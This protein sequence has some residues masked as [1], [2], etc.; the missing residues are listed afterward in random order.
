[1]ILDFYLQRQIL[2]QWCWAAVAASIS[3]SYDPNSTWQQS[4][5]AAHL[6]NGS[7]LNVT[8]PGSPAA[9]SCNQPF[10]LITALKNC[11]HNYAW[12]VNRHLTLAEIQYQISNRWPLCCLINWPNYNDSHYI[13][14]HGYTGSLLAISDP[15]IDDTRYLDYY[16]MVNNN[17]RGG[18]WVH[19]Y[20]TQSSLIQ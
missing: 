2:D 16:S 13:V 8:D 19:S 1:M 17:Y 18:Q 6:I 12:D 10:S 14:I 4:V 3:L 15:E 20:G 9:G 11:T 7:C 5:L